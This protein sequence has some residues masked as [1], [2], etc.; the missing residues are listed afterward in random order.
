[1]RQEYRLTYEYRQ[2]IV[3]K[4]CEA[5]VRI[6]TA[7][8]STTSGEFAFVGPALDQKMLKLLITAKEH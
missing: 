5:T 3:W 8:G 2:G 1:M 7:L 4:S 6:H